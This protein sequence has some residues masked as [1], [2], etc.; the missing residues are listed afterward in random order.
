MKKRF[1]IAMVGLVALAAIGSY[2]WRLESHGLDNAAV[3]FGVPYDVEPKNAE[4]LHDAKDVAL[5]AGETDV[6]VA[7]NEAVRKGEPEYHEIR[8][9]LFL[10]QKTKEG[11]GVWHL[12]MTSDGGWKDADGMDEWCKGWAKDVGASLYVMKARLSADGRGVWLVC[13]P[14]VGTYYLVCRYNFDDNTFRVFCDGDSIDEQPD[15]TI[16]IKNRKTYLQDEKGEPLGAAWYD[17]W[18]APDGKVVRK[19]KPISKS[20]LEKE[21]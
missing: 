18:I 13:D 17:E 10:R 1:L 9:S 12:I 7:H 5:F 15:G 19:S 2:V 14:H 6:D 16:L 4:L 20:E 8:N 21:L 3:H 11:T